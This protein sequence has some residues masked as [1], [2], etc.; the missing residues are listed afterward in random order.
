MATNQEIMAASALTS[1]EDDMVK[2]VAYTIVLLKRDKERIME[3]GQ[4]SVIVTDNMTDEAFTAMIVAKYLQQE[5]GDP[6]DATGEK[7]MPRSKLM[8]RDLEPGDLK[9]LRVHYVVSRRWPREPRE[10]EEHQIDWLQRIR[11]AM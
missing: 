3:G 11:D 1:L 6:D 5:V 4:D 2:L 9:Y 7:M 10:F 8:E